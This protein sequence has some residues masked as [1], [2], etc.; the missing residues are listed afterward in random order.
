MIDNP[1]VRCVITRNWREAWIGKEKLAK[2]LC[3]EGLESTIRR[4]K[5]YEI[6]FI[7]GR[8]VHF[9]PMSEFY[10]WS[11]GRTYWIGDRVEHSGYA[12]NYSSN[13]KELS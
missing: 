3:E 7:D 12:V 10:K 8:E 13:E 11:K 6:D 2:K 4:V 9:V 5:Q 1:K